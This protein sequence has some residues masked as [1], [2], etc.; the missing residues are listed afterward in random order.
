MRVCEIYIFL[1]EQDVINGAYHT[2]IE[3][4]LKYDECLENSRN[5]N[6]ADGTVV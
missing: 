2:E 6:K 1:I 3:Q 5:T 4:L